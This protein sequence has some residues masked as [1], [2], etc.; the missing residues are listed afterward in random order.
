M[1]SLLVLGAFLRD[2]LEMGAFSYYRFIFLL[3][4]VDRWK[5][6]NRLVIVCMM[7]TAKEVQ[8]LCV[9]NS[10]NVTFATKTHI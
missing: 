3:A 2:N 7:K 5:V 1:E 10:K 6:Y 4:C 9:S 8:C